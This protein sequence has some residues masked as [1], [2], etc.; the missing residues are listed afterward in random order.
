MDENGNNEQDKNGEVIKQQDEV[1]INPAFENNEQ[2]NTGSTQPKSNVSIK[3]SDL[4]FDVPIKSWK[5]SKCGLT[6]TVESKQ[7]LKQQNGEI[8]GAQLI[9]LMGPSGAGKSSLL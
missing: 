9:A 1:Y 4:T 2:I 3:W 7:I 6:R 5:L 8:I